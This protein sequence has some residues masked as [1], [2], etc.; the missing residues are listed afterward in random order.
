MTTTFSAYRIDRRDGAQQLEFTRLTE[1][2]LMEGNVTVAVEYSTLNYKDGLALT[3]RSPIVRRFPLIPGIDFAGRVV[4]S[5]D[6]RFRPGDR[7]VLNGYGVG[8]KHSGGYAGRARVPGDWLVAL[9]EGL[10]SRQAMAIGTAGYTAML[11][12]LALESHGLEPGAGEVLVTGA[13]GGVGSIAVALLGRLGH[14]VTAVTGRPHEADYLRELGATEILDRAEFT[15]PPRPL[16]SERWAAAIDVA[17]GL[18]LANVLSRMQRA[19]AVAACGLADA[20]ELPTTVAPFILRGVTLYG[21][22]SVMA[23]HALRERAWS[24]LARDLD[25]DRLETMTREVDFAQ[26]PQAAEEILAG[27]VRGR[28]VVRIPEAD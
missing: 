5:G 12:V 24:R 6:P 1:A 14:R 16:E 15:Q 19:S 4:E 17:G 7:V 18:T 26:L 2:D 21:I 22:D 23:P 28:T 13:A 8:E 11:A 9:P 3:G 20:M 10:T 25:L 27:R